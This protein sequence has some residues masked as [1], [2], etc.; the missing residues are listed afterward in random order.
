MGS[1]INSEINTEMTLDEVVELFINKKLADME[2]CFPCKV[3]KLYSDA[4]AVDIET[5]INDV[6]TVSKVPVRQIINGDGCSVYLPIK[7]GSKGVCHTFD[8]DTVKYFLDGSKETGSQKA[9]SLDNCYFVAGVVPFGDAYSPRDA[10]QLEIVNN[11]LKIYTDSDGKIAIQ[12]STV[13]LV[14]S[15][16]SI[17][18]KLNTI[19]DT[20][21][22]YQGFASTVPVTTNPAYT[23]SVLEPLQAS[24]DVLKNSLETLKL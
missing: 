11:G 17:M 9:H 4:Q 2:I 20:I 14:D 10:G 1:S 19:I 7:V 16:L 24:I 21:A 6:L 23:S 8:I 13:E 15:C 3:T 18:D 5:V 12:N 22:N